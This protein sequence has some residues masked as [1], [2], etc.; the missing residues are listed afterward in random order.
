[1]I[2]IDFPNHP[3]RIKE[4]A[5]KEMIWDEFRKKW[6]VLTPEEWVRQNILQYMVQVKNY[7]PSLIALERELQ[8][9][10][11]R[12]RFDIVVYNHNHQ[13]WLMVEC[14]AMHVPVSEH[15]LQQII[16]YN[17][18][19]PVTYLMIT[20]GSYTFCCKNENGQTEWLK[21]LPEWELRVE[22]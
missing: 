21:A 2:K 12:K 7:P 9:A 14:K 15:V 17:M 10:E 3:F 18:A 5:G 4:E 8:I 19:L 13:P 20:N 16:Q 22:S 6:I 11:V 1:M